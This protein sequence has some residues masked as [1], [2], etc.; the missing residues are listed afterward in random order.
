MLTYGN[1]TVRYVCDSIYI[2]FADTKTIRNSRF[3]Q[4][5]TPISKLYIRRKIEEINNAG[6]IG[7]RGIFGMYPSQQLTGTP[8]HSDLPSSLFFSS[9]Y[10][11]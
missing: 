8:R 3:Y 9:I 7:W 1:I 6:Q 11:Y 10:T 2:W 4:I 5:K